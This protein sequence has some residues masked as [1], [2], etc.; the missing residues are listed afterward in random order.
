L[1]EEKAK[2]VLTNHS[3]FLLEGTGRSLSQSPSRSQ[4]STFAAAAED[5][6]EAA[7]GEEDQVSIA[8]LKRKHIKIKTGEQGI[9]W[10]RHWW[11]YCAVLYGVLLLYIHGN[12][13]KPC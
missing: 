8:V 12:G 6:V 2:Q 5:S 11:W 7:E 9:G 4:L 13:R 1:N 3:S 10:W